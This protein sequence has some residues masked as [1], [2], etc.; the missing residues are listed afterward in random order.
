MPNAVLMKVP[1]TSAAANAVAC[2]GEGSDEPESA[3]V[4][5]AHCADMF[6]GL[7]VLE[8]G[9][10]NER[11]KSIKAPQ[12][13][14]AG[15]ERFPYLQPIQPVS[16]SLR[17]PYTDRFLVGRKWLAINEH[18]FVLEISCDTIEKANRRL[19][20]TSRA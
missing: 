1:S 10:Q 17:I 2:C 7:E 20:L 4:C 16:T 15:A 8:T 12:Q 18:S 3:A 19:Q 9:I 11:C 5:S 14:D 6:D 13:A